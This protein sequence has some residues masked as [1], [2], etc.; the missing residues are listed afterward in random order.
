MIQKEKLIE[1]RENGKTLSEIAEFFGV[2]T[3]TVKRFI[4]K[5]NLQIKK[6]DV[7][8]D[9]FIKLYNEYLEDSEI[10]LKLNLKKG[11]ITSYRKSLNLE[12]QSSRK[13]KENKIKFKELY[14]KGLNDTEISKLLNVNNVTIKNWREELSLSTNFKY[15]HKFNTEKFKELYDLGLNYTEIAKELNVSDSAISEYGHNLG[16]EPNTYNKLMPSY[17]EEQILLGTILGDAYLKK[18]KATHHASGNFAH[19]LAQERYCKWKE[20]KLKNFVSGS[21][22]KDEYDKR[23]EKVYSCYYVNLKASKYLDLIYSK[24]YKD[25]IKYIDKELLYKV[26][27]LGLAVWFMDDGYKSNCGYYICTNCFDFKDLEIIQNY[28]LDKYN[29][30]TTIQAGNIL[31]IGASFKDKFTQLIK[32]YIHEDCLYKLHMSH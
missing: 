13:R 24:F 3:S 11:T 22:Y 20:E 9:E 30:A 27:A 8:Y 16:L 10:A 15:E 2:S 6:K 14:D 17:E 31:Y 29:I 5:N 4:A 25:K 26:D 28:F 12:S 1:L 19:S 23:T 7:D 32:D 18:M 21:G